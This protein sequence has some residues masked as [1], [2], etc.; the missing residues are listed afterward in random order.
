MKSYLLRELAGEGGR[1]WHRWATG[2]AGLHLD[3]GDLSRH[4]GRESLEWRKKNQ[5]ILPGPGR[6]RRE[7]AG[8]VRESPDQTVLGQDQAWP[9]SSQ[10]AVWCHQGALGPKTWVQGPILPIR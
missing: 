6:A 9:W 10:G 5:H 3:R 4:Q 7:A 8:K 1:G 2:E